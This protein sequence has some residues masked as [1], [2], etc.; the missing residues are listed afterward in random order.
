MPRLYLREAEPFLPQ[1]KKI[2]ME[3]HM[4]GGKKGHH[5]GSERSDPTRQR[6]LTERSAS[7]IGCDAIVV[8]VEVLQILGL[9]Q[10]MGLKW[11]WPETWIK[12]AN[13][14]FIFNADAWEFTK[15]QSR[16]YTRLQGKETAS[17]TIPADYNHIL[18]AWAA[19]LLI[20]GLVFLITF[21]VLRRRQ[22]PYLMVHYAN[23]ERIFLVL[24]QVLALPL[25]T[26]V[27]R[28]F[29]CTDGDKMAVFN[30]VSCHEGMYWAYVAPS[31]LLGVALFGAVPGWMVYRIRKQKMAAADRHHD[32]YL[33][34]K[35]VEYEAGLDVVWAVQGFHL[36]SSFRLCAVYYRPIVHMFKL[37][38]LIFFS[39]LFLEIH[40]QAICMAVAL[41]LAAL[42]MPLIRP[43]RVASFN[44]VLCLSLS[45]LAG[46]A[47]FGSVVTSVTPAS[48]ESPWLVEPYSYAIL[49]GINV[50]LACSLL[51]WIVWLVC[52]MKC[53]CCTKVCFP[54]SPLWPTL[55][56][57]EFKVDGAETYK[58][59]AAVLRARAV[60]GK[61]ESEGHLSKIFYNLPGGM[62]EFQAHCYP[63]D[64][65]VDFILFVLKLCY[66]ES[67]NIIETLECKG[68]LVDHLIC[69]SFS[70]LLLSNETEGW[71][72]GAGRD[73][74]DRE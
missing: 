20:T 21:L 31:I 8:V 7:L 24:V 26:A 27:F 3:Q 18:M 12:Y 56:S 32:V 73:R 14:I 65:I 15:V 28:L 33:R 72:Q 45:S 40:A 60:L 47:I 68:E 1:D 44:V 62:A 66:K 23:M 52:R 50:I 53:S 58:F 37:M 36:F 38:L 16:A 5:S 69:M 13:F 10:S 49:T 57:Y 42:L 51:V 22:P 34:L 59:M 71:R 41:T 46:N 2:A 17:S 43:F 70:S 64:K 55:L 63:G 19:L 9:T 25:G 30:S 4:V 48:V 54:N 61:A 29:H 67:G 74:R 39:A 35:E 6:R 11:S